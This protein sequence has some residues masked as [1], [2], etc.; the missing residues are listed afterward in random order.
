MLVPG[1]SPASGLSSSTPWRGSVHVEVIEW[2][3][4]KEILVM[5]LTAVES[6]DNSRLVSQRLGTTRV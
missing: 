6:V 1:T 4:I 5:V 2:I 3:F